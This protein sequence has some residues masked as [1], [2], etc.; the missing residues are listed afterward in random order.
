[1]P[2][3]YGE[4]HKS[5]I[6]LQHKILRQTDDLSLLAWYSSDCESQRFCGVLS[7]SPSVFRGCEDIQSLDRRTMPSSTTS[8]GLKIHRK[9]FKLTAMDGTLYYAIAIAK[10]TQPN[11]DVIHIFLR[12]RA[13]GFDLYERVPA[14]PLLT[15]K[16]SLTDLPIKSNDKLPIWLATNADQREMQADTTDLEI[17]LRTGP[18]LQIAKAVPEWYWDGDSFFRKPPCLFR[19]FSLIGNSIE[20]NKVEL[21]LLQVFTEGARTGEGR[22]II[23]SVDEY[24]TE[25]KKLLNLSSRDSLS[26][27]SLSHDYP[28][29]DALR[30]RRQ[31]KINGSLF[32]VDLIEVHDV[33]EGKH[34]R[35]VQVN[36]I[37]ERTTEEEFSVP[38]WKLRS[39][40]A[41]KSKTLGL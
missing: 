1:M 11:G 16:H 15:S 3:L 19:V 40:S 34:Y 23:F 29:L 24:P 33:K 6:R 32:L 9:V 28:A 8:R 14:A 17:H 25:A 22:H 7:D 30:S 21:V 36:K 2:L 35:E 4:R 10:V 26:L 20:L 12:V 38:E 39:A 5:F 13:A 31:I 41:W 18:K 37:Q 27:E